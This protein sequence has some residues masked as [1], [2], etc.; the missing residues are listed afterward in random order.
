MKPEPLHCPPTDLPH[1]NFQIKEEPPSSQS[2][3]RDSLKA[4]HGYDLG[5]SP[6]LCSLDQWGCR[7]LRQQ[8]G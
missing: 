6:Y 3:A 8:A 2:Q 5:Q 1:T 4:T 7:G